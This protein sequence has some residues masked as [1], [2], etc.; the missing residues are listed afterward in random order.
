MEF[1]GQFMKSLSPGSLS[2]FL[3]DLDDDQNQF[4]GTEF[5]NLI[6]T[7][8]FPRLFEFLSWE[9]D[10]KIPQNFNVSENGF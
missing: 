10:I 3:Y 1:L 9:I 8:F 2:W 6:E 4:Y 5:E 7:K